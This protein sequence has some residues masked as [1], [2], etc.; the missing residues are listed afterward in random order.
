MEFFRKHKKGIIGTL[1][2]H[3]FVA[4]ILVFFKFSTPLPLPGEEGILIN[5]GDEE[6]GSGPVE[7]ATNPVQ[8]RQQPQPQV[9]ET[10]EAVESTSPDEAITQDYEE[11]P[12]MKAND[13][14]EPQEEE[15]EVE[16]PVEKKEKEVK[17]EPKPERKVNEMALYKGKTDND[18][19]SE[20]ETEGEGNQGNPTGS[21]DSK[22]HGGGDS[23]GGSGINFSLAGRNP[24]S[25]P[26]PVYN[27]QAEGKVVVE[28][29]VNKYGVV[30]DAVPGVRGS[31]T[32][33]A[34]LLNAAKKAALKA[35]FDRKPDAP[36]FQKGTITYFFK[37]Q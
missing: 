8:S 25:L 14:E 6:M 29:T 33:D 31:T 34:N 30:T 27:F 4:L 32:L 5:F 12:E 23:S 35:K 11:A 10:N 28:I 16:K 1:L 37:L 21:T 2:F 36:A 22:N 3:G 17:E 15:K 13:A 7:P 20:G 9:E 19:K 26:K 24:E 18:S